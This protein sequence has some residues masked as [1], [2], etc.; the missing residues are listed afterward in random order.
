MAAPRA[1]RR[2]LLVTGFLVLVQAGVG[3][4][5]NLYGLFPFHRQSSQAGAPRIR[6]YE[7]FAWAVGHGTPALAVHT[8]LGLTLVLLSIVAAT[9]AVLLRQRAVAFWTVL[10]ALLVIG[11]AAFG[12]SFL[13]N[14][15]T[16]Y[17]LLMA[18][19]AL[20]SEVCFHLAVDLLPSGRHRAVASNP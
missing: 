16:L 5:I 18:L 3:L 1:V 10:G 9:R 2:L 6:A 15:K 17:S 12:G 8:A 13:A 19:F 11:A 14:G 7:S 20:S 4:V